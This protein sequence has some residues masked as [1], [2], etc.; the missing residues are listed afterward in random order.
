MEASTP[1]HGRSLSLSPTHSTPAARGP[2]ER[3][4]TRYVAIH[5]I[6][7]DTPD[8]KRCNAYG[9]GAPPPTTSPTAG[10]SSPQPPTVCIG[11]RHTAS[12]CSP[13]LRTRGAAPV[14]SRNTRYVAMH[15][16]RRGVMPTVRV[17]R[18]IDNK[19]ARRFT[20]WRRRR[21]HPIAPSCAALHPIRRTT[22]DPSRYTRSEGVYC[23]RIG[24]AIT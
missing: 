12:T 15:P 1:T 19:L 23:L 5:P 21:R 9:S 6:R 3:R 7:R 2:H 10:N 11:R 17:H 24:C 8:Q 14:T 13:R 4:Y 22:P 18:L 16:I 20:R